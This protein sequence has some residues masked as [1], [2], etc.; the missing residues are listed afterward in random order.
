[1]SN[2]KRTFDVDAYE[3][4]ILYTFSKADYENLKHEFRG[5]MTHKKY[6]IYIL[7]YWTKTSIRFKALQENSHERFNSNITEA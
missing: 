3:F 2:S 5:L 7:R 1:M 6:Y 4:C